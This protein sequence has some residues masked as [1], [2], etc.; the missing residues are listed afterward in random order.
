MTV[1]NRN[2][3]YNRALI[4]ED[5]E[6][7]VDLL[8][9]HLSD[10]GYEVTTSGNGLEGLELARDGS[11]ELVILDIQLPGLDGLEVCKKIRQSDPKTPT[12]PGAE[13]VLH[14]AANGHANG[15]SEG[16]CVQVMIAP[17]AKDPSIED[18]VA[19]PGA[20]CLPYWIVSDQATEE[21]EGSITIPANLE[22]G[23][24]IVQC[25]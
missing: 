21:T 25:S 18:F 2:Q 6:S 16:T 15:Q 22:P 24:I 1:E 7:I 12:K 17:F 8:K 20:E 13:V 5:D 9:I 14:W 10:I 23:R 19:I 3:V 4:V 11:F